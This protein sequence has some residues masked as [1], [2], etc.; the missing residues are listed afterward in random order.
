MKGIGSIT[1]TG[2]DMS[3]QG[4]FVT[5]KDTSMSLNNALKVIPFVSMQ[6]V[7]LN[8][9]ENAA[10]TIFM[11]DLLDQ[12]VD[13]AGLRTTKQFTVK[14]MSTRDTTILTVKTLAD[15]AEINGLTEEPKESWGLPSYMIIFYVHPVESG[16]VRFIFQTDAIAG[17]ESAVSGLANTEVS[18]EA[19]ANLMKQSRTDLIRKLHEKD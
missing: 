17:G 13:K 8:H 16:L 12:V 3:L 9:D 2:R 14:D 7:Y 10:M 1:S 15:D 6:N 5:Y 11:R 4:L 18:V 19:L